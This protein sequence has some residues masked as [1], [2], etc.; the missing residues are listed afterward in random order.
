M[1]EE[2][3][4]I[5]LKDGDPLNVCKRRLTED[6]R[7][8]RYLIEELNFDELD[9]ED[10]SSESVTLFVTLLDDKS[11]GNLET[12]QFR[13]QHKLG[14]VFEVVW[15]VKEGQCAHPEPCSIRSIALPAQRHRHTH[16]RQA[17][18]F[19]AEVLYHL[20]SLGIENGAPFFSKA[21]L[22]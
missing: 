13:E 2:T 17:L 10:F 9:L 15:L 12:A 7:K 21:L 14:H 20:A 22:S 8:F 11:I 16:L 5:K 3:I 18:A 1:N 4:I 19:L 6:S